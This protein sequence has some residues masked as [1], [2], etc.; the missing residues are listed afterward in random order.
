MS[1]RRK[2]GKGGK[3][4]AAAGCGRRTEQE[5]SRRVTVNLTEEAYRFV[6]HC[7]TGFSFSDKLRYV[8]TVYQ[9]TTGKQVPIRPSSE[10]EQLRLFK[11]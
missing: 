2:H 11:E 9:L 1:F 10:P 6:Q 3:V 8:I 7:V 5:M 4:R